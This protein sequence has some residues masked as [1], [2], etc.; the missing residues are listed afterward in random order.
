MRLILVLALAALALAVPLDRFE[1]EIRAYEARPRPAAG[2]LLFLGSS[3][4]R[5]WGEELERE[6]LPLRAVNRGFGGAT[7]A[8]ITYYY[9]RLGGPLQPRRIVFYAGTNDVAEGHSAGEI[10]ADFQSFLRAAEG[11]P[12]TFVSM[13]IPPS[14]ARFTPIYQEANR[15]IRATGVDYLDVSQLLQDKTGQ[16]DPAFFADDMLHMN[17]RGYARWTPVLH[18]HLE[19]K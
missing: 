18:R 12:V 7:I 13:S 9:P 11:V 10:L 17:A 6:F 5:L 4:I 1:G 15:L 16:P 19:G 2:C 14:R 8:E 3:T